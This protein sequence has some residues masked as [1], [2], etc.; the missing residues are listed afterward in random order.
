M[1]IVQQWT[2]KACV[3]ADSTKQVAESLERNN[4]ARK[5]ADD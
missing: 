4:Q 2:C 1:K 3:T 5:L